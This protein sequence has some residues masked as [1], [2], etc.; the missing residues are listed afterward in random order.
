MTKTVPAAS[1]AD[2]VA[3]MTPARTKPVS[4]GEKTRVPGWTVAF[5]PIA[6]GMAT[7]S[8][9]CGKSDWRAG[10][11]NTLRHEW[12]KLARMTCQTST[13]WTKHN[14]AST[15]RTRMSI[16]CATM[17]KRRWSSR[18]AMAPPSSARAVA[19]TA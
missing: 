19:G 12:I 8:T 17:S 15:A 13:D 11:S 10:C 2:A 9:R 18:S 3:P 4:T 16:N 5:R 7:R 14:M 6:L 1:M